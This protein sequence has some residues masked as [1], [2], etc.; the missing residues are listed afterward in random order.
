[1][2]WSKI[3]LHI[4]ECFSVFQISIQSLLNRPLVQNECHSRPLIDLIDSLKHHNYLRLIIISKSIHRKF[5]IFIP[6][7]YTHA[8]VNIAGPR[9]FRRQTS[10][11]RRQ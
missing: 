11:A 9:R 4:F 5:S 3:C 10:P 6:S 8:L 7:K 2:I 1:M